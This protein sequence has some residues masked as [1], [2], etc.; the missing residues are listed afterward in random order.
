[1]FEYIDEEPM[2]EKV[3]NFLHTP[4]N[5]NKLMQQFPLLDTEQ[6]VT[7]VSDS[8][9]KILE[10]YFMQIRLKDMNSE[11]ESRVC[12]LLLEYCLAWE[13]L[14]VRYPASPTLGRVLP[15]VLS[16]IV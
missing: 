8:L 12:Q 2:E 5:Y 10:R 3:H 7:D 11:E 15:R 13:D 6:V 16:K 1:M 9:L 14:L 4:Q